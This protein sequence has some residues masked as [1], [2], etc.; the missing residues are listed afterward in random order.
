MKL[1]SIDASGKT[2]ACAITENDVTLAKSFTNSGLTHSQTL[3]PMID[4]TLEIA[5]VDITEIDEF[6]L[7]IGPGSFT[8]LR[9]GAATVMGLA[10]DKPCK[11]VSTLTAIAYNFLDKNAII[12][13]TLDARRS[14]V[15]TAVF[16]CENGAITTLESDMAISVDKA[17]EKADNYSKIST[18]YIAGDGAYLFENAIDNMQNVFIAENDRLFPQGDAIAKAAVN[19]PTVCAKDIKLCYL[20][21]SQAERELKE[22]TKND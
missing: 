7:T 1:L 8:G 13:P 12:I 21:L 4:K 3:L 2:A 18:V 20:R 15:Y 14:Q 6:A 22:K 9:I 5:S 17:L 19:M 16:K 10:S 11:C